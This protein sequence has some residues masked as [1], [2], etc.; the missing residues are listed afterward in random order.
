MTSA[1]HIESLR[2]HGVRLLGEDGTTREIPENFLE[3]TTAMLRQTGIRK[4]AYSIKVPETEDEML[5]AIWDC[6]F[7]ESGSA[8]E[9]LSHEDR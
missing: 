7:A 1:E 6:G 3:T 4:V 2:R 9:I 8:D 5:L